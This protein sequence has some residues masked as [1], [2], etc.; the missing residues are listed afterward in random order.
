[1]AVGLPSKVEFTTPSVNGHSDVIPYWLL[2]RKTEFE[3]FNDWQ[4]L[5]LRARTLSL[6]TTPSRV[7]LPTSASIPTVQPWTVVWLTD[8]SPLTVKQV[9]AFRTMRFVTATVPRPIS[10]S[11]VGG[12]PGVSA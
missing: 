3:I 2:A 8:T 1:M 10:P 6:A 5:S 9:P 11:H 12:V 4:W 7:T